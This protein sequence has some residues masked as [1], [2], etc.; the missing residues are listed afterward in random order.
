MRQIMFSKTFPAY[1]PRKGE[2]TN[3]ASGICKNVYGK[4]FALDLPEVPEKLHTIRAGQNWKV[5]DQFVPKMWSG[6]P[7]HTKPV[8]FLNPLTVKNVFKFRIT[9]KGDYLVNG[10]KQSVAQLT[11]IAKNDGF[12]NLDDFEL[13]FSKEKTF[14]GQIIC[15]SDNVNY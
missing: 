1:H 3:F 11:E 10:K 7:Y 14:N 4:D 5:G 12:T 13:W 8:P 2:L 15:W 6:R 9:A